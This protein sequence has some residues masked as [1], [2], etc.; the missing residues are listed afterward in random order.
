MAFTTELTDYEC[1]LECLAESR[2]Q[3]RTMTVVGDQQNVDLAKAFY[4]MDM[5]AAAISA[6]LADVARTGNSPTK[7]GLQ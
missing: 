3:L 1:L 2:E 4:R 5:A 6:L 7:K